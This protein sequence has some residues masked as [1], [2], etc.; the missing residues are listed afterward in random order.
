MMILEQKE[1]LGE[2]SRD[3]YL[4]IAQEAAGKVGK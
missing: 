1:E 3:P 2:N 4:V